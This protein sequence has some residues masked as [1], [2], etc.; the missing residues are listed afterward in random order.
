MGW[1]ERPY[2]L[3]GGIIGLVLGI[4]LGFILYVYFPMKKFALILCKTFPC[5]QVAYY[6]EPLFI[7]YSP[8]ILFIVGTLIGWIV[9]K[10]KSKEDIKE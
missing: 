7:L 8:I 5:P 1:K 4:V 6:N 2:W 10:V 9:G 3:K